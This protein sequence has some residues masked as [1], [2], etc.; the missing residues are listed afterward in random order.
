MS[1]FFLFRLPLKSKSVEL[2][3]ICVDI[4]PFIFLNL[5]FNNLLDDFKNWGQLLRGYKYCLLSQVDILHKYIFKIT[6]IF[7]QQVFDFWL[8]SDHMKIL[9][10]LD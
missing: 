1:A 9:Y 6:F 8:A 5:E 10:G 7:L 3:I 2:H 4:L